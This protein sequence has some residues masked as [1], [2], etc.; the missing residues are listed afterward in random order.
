MVVQMRMSTL[1]KRG[2][3]G[4]GH[5]RDKAAEIPAENTNAYLK[6]LTSAVVKKVYF[7]H[8]STCDHM[9]FLRFYLV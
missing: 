9:V 8:M 1:G 7:F 4:K 3:N 2:H 6:I 5:E